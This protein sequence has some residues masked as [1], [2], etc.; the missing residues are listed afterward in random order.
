ML[1]SQRERGCLLHADKS[2]LFLPPEEHQR[3]CFKDIDSS[4]EPDFG[5]KHFFTADPQIFT[6]DL[7][8]KNKMHGK[9]WIV[10]RDT[11]QALIVLRSLVFVKLI[12]ELQTWHQAKKMDAW[13]RI[14]ERTGKKIESLHMRNNDWREDYYTRQ[15]NCTRD[16]P[17]KK[18]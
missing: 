6:E 15:K 11:R 2:A 1:W 8:D 18:D 9:F 10:R 13:G 3:F 7:H 12:C 4:A 14:H 17:W 5:I 16:K